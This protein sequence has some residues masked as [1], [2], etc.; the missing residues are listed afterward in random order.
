MAANTVKHTEESI[1]IRPSSSDVGSIA[2]EIYDRVCRA[3]F[4]SP[5]FCLFSLGDSVDSVGLRRLMVDLKREMKAIHEARTGN[6]LV[7]LSA[8][9]FDQQVTTRLHLD[10]GPDECFLMLGYEPSEV[11][12]A[13]SIADYARCAFDL[14]LSPKDFMSK[15]NPMFGSGDEV[16]QP[17]TTRVPC[18][19]SSEFQIVCINNSSA[20]YSSTLPLWQGTLH[21]ATI[22]TPDESK[23]RIINS[24]MIASAP[25]G[26]L[27]TITELQQEQF[28]TTSAVR[29][30]GYDKQHLEDDD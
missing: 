8:T 22:L 10:G 20:A 16:L 18:F 6:T 17:Y 21:T 4:D 1:C 26:T 12:S 29:R 27:D 7:Y 28:I 3:D 9:R 15:H 23:R 13:I 11:E 2:V 24:T 25:R 30:Q 5:G 19:S 14:G